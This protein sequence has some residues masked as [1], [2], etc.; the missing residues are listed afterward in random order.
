MKIKFI[1]CIAF[2]VPAFPAHAQ[3]PSDPQSYTPPV[4]QEEQDNLASTT[5]PEASAHTPIL[6]LRARQVP[7]VAQE[8][9][10]VPP[11]TNSEGTFEH[12]LDRTLLPRE[13]HRDML[14]T[15][16]SGEE[17]EKVLLSRDAFRPLALP[18]SEAWTSVDAAQREGIIA[19]AEE[20]LNYEWP[21]LIAIRYMDFDINGDRSR[22]S[23]RYFDR[24]RV[25]AKLVLAEIL[26][27]KGRFMDDIINGLWLICEETTWVVPAHSDGDKL[28]DINDVYVDLFSAETAALLAWTDYFLGT[29]L[30][31]FTPL[32]RQRIHQETDRRVITSM[33]ENDDFWYMGYTGRIPNNWNPWVVSNWLATVLLLEDD[34]ETRVASVQ[35]ALDVLDNY[36]NPHPPD[37]GCDEGPGY[38]A[39]AAASLFDCLFLLEDA[40]GGAID[41]FNEPLIRNMATYIYKINIADGW[42]V[43]FADG[44]ARNRHAPGTIYRI[45]KA[46]GD[47]TMMAFAAKLYAERE[48]GRRGESNGDS[49][50]DS[51]SVSVRQP[52]GQRTIP[53]LLV[54]KE[55]TAFHGAFSPEPAYYFPDLEVAV[56]RGD[57]DGFF[58]AIKGGFNDESHNHNDVGTFVV[59]AGGL[60]LLIDAGVGTYTAKTFSSERYTIWTMQSAYH[61]LP[62]INGEMQAYGKEY[63]AGSFSFSDNGRKAVASVTI[64]GAYPEAAAV[65]AWKRTITLHRKPAAMRVQDTY[66]LKTFKSP[67]QWHFMAAFEPEIVSGTK[68][69]LSNGEKRFILSHDRGL[70]AEIEEIGIRDG[71]LRGTWHG[72]LF[73]ITL[74]STAGTL[75]GN[76]TFDIKPE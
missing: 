14:T 65:D 39:R 11:Y 53:D 23:G 42:Y 75:S 34:H 27:N 10:G 41:V 7:S 74:T 35:K 58:Y 22:F 46:I 68:I 71:R 8:E 43:N 24:R 50:G 16:I 69:R 2:L 57:A 13:A 47:S 67:Q 12:T 56:A 3:G 59:F 29:K 18:G 1:V 32:I 61:N 5:D 17:L 48:G 15:S 55:L 21:S 25:L 64:E 66:T 30:D 20:Y 33:L 62:T 38:W 63:R 60:P 72:N 73:R 36:L 54:E 49:S 4:P 44:S 26:E 70:R 9:R 6:S 40:T 51:R 31:A 76:E 52:V 37:G 19:E 28:H 45:G